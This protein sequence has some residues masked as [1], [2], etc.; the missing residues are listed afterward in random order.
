MKDQLIM[1]KVYV[2][3]ANVNVVVAY[4]DALF[5]QP[6]VAR[7]RQQGSVAMSTTQLQDDGS[8]FFSE[9]IALLVLPYCKP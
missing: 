4:I 9:I 6:W 8:H 3:L 1:A 2:S 5:L 7:R